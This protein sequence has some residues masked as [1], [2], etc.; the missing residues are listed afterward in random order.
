[1]N[2]F[3]VS[4]DEFKLQHF[5]L[6]NSPEWCGTS[7]PNT[8]TWVIRKVRCFSKHGSVRRSQFLRS[9]R[10][11]RCSCVSPQE[12]FTRLQEKN[13]VLTRMKTTSVVARLFFSFRHGLL[14][15]VLHL[16]DISNPPTVF[17]CSAPDRE[18]KQ[19]P[20]LSLRLSEM[21]EV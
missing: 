14:Q 5:W 7:G 16:Q 3:Q 13:L 18:R 12:T 2:K 15:S 9:L 17:W 6:L 8:F 1:M 19:H 21:G 4:K 20:D 11:L 10:L